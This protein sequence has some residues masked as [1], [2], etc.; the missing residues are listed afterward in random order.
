MIRIDFVDK[1][2][3]FAVEVLSSKEPTLHQVNSVKVPQPFI[4]EYGRELYLK[5]LFPPEKV[6][7]QSADRMT[8]SIQ[9]Q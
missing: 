6:N 8:G 9:L 4:L 5:W 1:I 3:Y 7:E 2:F